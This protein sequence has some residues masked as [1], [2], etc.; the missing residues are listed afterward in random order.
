MCVWGASVG[1]DGINPWVNS[2]LRRAKR[3]PFGKS[4]FDGYHDPFSQG[5]L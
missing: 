4:E 3:V 2:A 1:E 5:A